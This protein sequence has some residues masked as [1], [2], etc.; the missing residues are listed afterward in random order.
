MN[1]V[2]VAGGL[3]PVDK[4]VLLC[5]ADRANDGGFCWPSVATIARETG[6]SPRGVQAALR[7]LRQLGLIDVRQSAGG[8]MSNVYRLHLAAIS[9]PERH[10]KAAPAEPE[11]PAPGAGVSYTEAEAPPHTVRGTPAPGA[12]VR[13]VDKSGTP[14]PGAG[15]PRTGC[16]APLHPVHPN[17]YITII[18]PLEGP[19]PVTPG[20]S[21]AERPLDGREDDG[22]AAETRRLTEA[23]RREAFARA[24][25]DFGLERE[26]RGPRPRELA[27]TPSAEPIERAASG[28]LPPGRPTPIARRPGPIVPSEKRR[29]GVGACLP[30]EAR[31]VLAAVVRAESA[32]AALP[33]PGGIVE[34]VGG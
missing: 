11:T 22:E 12:G 23:E 2:W 19:E 6:V 18:K 1:A 9:T 3:T 10:T 21:F 20:I 34:G 27:H 7:R 8:R 31:R 16:G 29:Q 24:L 30:A 4:I 26:V 32:G 13:G 14:A 5:L 28:A 17:P 33:D 25:A 15:H